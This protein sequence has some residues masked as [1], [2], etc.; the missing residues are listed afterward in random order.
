MK[1]PPLGLKVGSVLGTALHY[2][3]VITKHVKSKVY[4]FSP[5]YVK[6]ILKYTT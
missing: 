5:V 1:L 4:I 2:F 6:D 3:Y